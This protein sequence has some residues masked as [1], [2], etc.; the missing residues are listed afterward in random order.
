MGRWLPWVVWWAATASSAAPQ[1]LLLVELP[2]T[3]A[4][5]RGAE[6]RLRERLGDR[7]M[8]AAHTR[9]LLDEADA[10]GLR[11]PR[12][13]E[14]CAAG[15]GQLAGVDEVVAVVARPVGDGVVVIARRI[16][17]KGARVVDASVGR[18]TTQADDGGVDLDVVA[19]NLW[20]PARVPVPVP[21]E[22]QLDDGAVPEALVVDGAR[23]RVERGVLW[24][25]PGAHR[26]GVAD[27]RTVVEITGRVLPPPV[28]VARAPA[29]PTAPIAPTAPTAPIT[30]PAPVATTPPP[31]APAMS[32]EEGIP[33]GAVAVGGVGVAVVGALV[34]SGAEWWLASEAASV[35]RLAAPERILGEGV[36]AIGIVV[37][38][39][40]VIGA[41]G[42]ATLWWS[43]P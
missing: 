42:G 35:E 25:L 8:S 22:V 28:V 3:P 12:L 18:L 36:G 34:V 4:V 27:A 41:V 17:A 30:P 19:L 40:G 6:A 15:F 37:A 23:R 39:V 26:V 29:A 14:P 9:A 11:C 7:V 20:L 2:D 33:W 1:P 32:P 24:L 21:V 5:P 16:E 13:D 31:P 43:G 10:L 38:G